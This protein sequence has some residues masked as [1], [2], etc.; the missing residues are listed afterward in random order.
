M[1]FLYSNEIILQENKKQFNNKTFKTSFKNTLTR[2][3]ENRTFP[4]IWGTTKVFLR[5]KLTAI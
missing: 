5:E 2:E 3:N 4:N 1:S